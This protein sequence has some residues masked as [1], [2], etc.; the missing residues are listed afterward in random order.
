MS[1]GETQVPAPSGA[2]EETVGGFILENGPAVDVVGAYMIAGYLLIVSLYLLSC[3]LGRWWRSR[4]VMSEVAGGKFRLAASKGRVD[5][6]VGMKESVRDFDVNASVGGFTALHAACCQSELGAVLW[7]CQHGADV[8]GVKEDGWKY[9]AL[10][11]AS[12]RGDLD[13]VKVLC[14]FG[15]DIGST[16]FTGET[17]ST[18][19]DKKG[20]VVV[21]EYLESVASGGVSADPV[22][23]YCGRMFVRESCSSPWSLV[24]G[25]VER[26]SESDLASY[27][28]RGYEGIGTP[29]TQMG[30]RLKGFRILAIAYLS[31]SVLYLVWR[32]LRSLKPGWWYFYSIPFWLFEAV[33]WTLGLCFVYSLYYQIDRPGRDIAEMLEEDDFPRVDIFICRYSEPVE[34]LEATVVAALNID[35]PGKKLCVHIL[36]D[37]NS[38]EVQSMKRRLVYQMRYMGRHANL[39]Y[40]ARPKV[41]GVPHHAKAGNINHCLLTESSTLTDYILVL[42]CDMIIHPTFLRRTL[43][44]FMVDSGGGEWRHKDFAALLQTPQDFWNVDRDDPMV[45]CA[46]F[47][48]GPM[49]MGRDGAGALPCCGTGVIFKRDI[50][51]SVGGQSY[52]SVTEDCNTAMQ[53]LSSGFA[54]MFMDERLVYGMAPETL[55]G[56]FKQRLRWAMGAIQIL[57]R[58]NPLRKR[59]LTVAQSC[60]FFEIGAHHYLAFGTAFMAVVPLFYVFL[61]VSPVVV[62]YLWEFCIVFGVFFISNRLMMVW[63]HKG[64]PTGG[65]LELWR[66]GQLWVWMCPNHVEASIRTF[67]AEA[68]L[69]RRITFEIKFSVTEKHKGSSSLLQSL[70]CTWI[71]VLYLVASA[72]A[73]VMFIVMASLQKY[74]AWEILIKLTAVMWS[75][76]LCLCIWP[77]V[78]LLLPRIETEQGWRI[79][80]NQAL[81]ENAFMVDGKKRI[82]KK[83]RANS[84]SATKM[85]SQGSLERIEEGLRSLPPEKKR[86]LSRFSENVGRVALPQ[87]TAKTLL[88]PGVYTSTILPEPS[89]LSRKD[90]HRVDTRHLSIEQMYSQIHSRG[91]T[92]TPSRLLRNGSTQYS[93][94][95]AGHH[96]DVANY[97]INDGRIFKDGVEVGVQTLTDNVLA[98]LKLSS[99]RQNSP[100]ELMSPFFE[101]STDID[102]RTSASHQS[103]GE[104]KPKSFVVTD[105]GRIFKDERQVS[106][107]TLVDHVRAKVLVSSDSSGDAGDFTSPFEEITDE[108]SGSRKSSYAR[109]SNMMMSHPISMQLDSETARAYGQ[110]LLR[111]MTISQ[112]ESMS[113]NP[114]SVD[115]SGHGNDNTMKGDE[116][117]GSMVFQGSFVTSKLFRNLSQMQPSVLE[118]KG[119]VIP[120]VP[121]S[122]F[123]HTIASRPSF[124]FRI[125]PKT[126]IWF[127]LVNL[128]ILSGVIAAGILSIFYNSES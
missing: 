75:L 76:Y 108:I 56:V 67:F 90:S 95:I 53:L 2:G 22:D 16:T 19:A 121:D 10:H 88:Q 79:S 80:W 33:S 117:S 7:L 70:S 115:L 1:Q 96:R 124:D 71:F 48:Y 42:D 46:R 52:G 15:A 27:V 120:V 24:A 45:H 32:A 41:R 26:C 64:C 60:L 77:P 92:M 119:F 72:A 28:A 123:D 128:A 31:I 91:F 83:H 65:S 97:E 111:S 51:V 43:G 113:R 17:A 44:H 98:H 87:K 38:P 63:A 4:G 13:C 68:P 118:K 81:D 39:T 11:Y 127:F 110:E 93:H 62:E 74:T 104:M 112:N 5:V 6:L 122:V 86:L 29:G 25:C 50:L 55:F 105:S 30:R 8:H 34:V 37:G 116:V 57:Y 89:R 107:G 61:S 18:L 100:A 54:N 84:L 126:S 47:F 109:R 66:G 114:I 49:L 106:L 3:W 14:A 40:V 73:F 12:C 85:R 99:I 78:S 69:I 23:V 94:R 102:F 9:T 59:G 101:A 103:I 20:H 58:D 35:Y 21:S 36:D 82:V 125:L